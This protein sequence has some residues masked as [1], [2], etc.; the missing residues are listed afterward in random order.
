MSPAFC[1]ISLRRGGTSWGEHH[2]VRGVGDD[3][4][5]PRVKKGGKGGKGGVIPPYFSRGQAMSAAEIR[6][7]INGD[8]LLLEAVAPPSPCRAGT[9]DTP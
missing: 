8:D 4:F 6:V 3:S 2:G 1:C 7:G 5:L 9:H